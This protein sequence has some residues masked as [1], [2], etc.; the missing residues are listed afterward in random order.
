MMAEIDTPGVKIGVTTRRGGVSEA[1]FDALN[2]GDHV[3]DN[4][5]HVSQQKS[6][7]VAV[8]RPTYLLVTPSAWHS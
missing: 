8:N 3:G 5:A 7:A 4:P 2:L 1:P 6:I